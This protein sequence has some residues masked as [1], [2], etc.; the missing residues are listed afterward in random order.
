MNLMH[1]FW[2][3]PG[4]G[5]AETALCAQIQKR[6]DDPD[7]RPDRSDDMKKQVRVR[8]QLRDV[9]GARRDG[10]GVAREDLDAL[11]VRARDAGGEKR[12]SFSRADVGG[13]V[14]RLVHLALALPQA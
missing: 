11:G 10:D 12:H 13:G 9:V 5:R 4:A 7:H 6:A 1:D 14:R 3:H 2:C 8:G